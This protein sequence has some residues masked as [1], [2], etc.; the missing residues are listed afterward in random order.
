MYER[1][2]RIV[3]DSSE[4]DDSDGEDEDTGSDT[5]DEG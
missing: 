3:D 2:F 1:Y 4:S 5:G